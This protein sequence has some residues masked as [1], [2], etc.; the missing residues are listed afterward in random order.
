[1]SETA[2]GTSGRPG[3]PADGAHAA[4][5]ADAAHP[6]GVA[7]GGDVVNRDPDHGPN[8]DGPT[9]TAAGATAGTGTGTHPHEDHPHALHPHEESLADWEESVE[10][11]IEETV[12]D[13]RADVRKQPLAVWV[14]AAAAVFAF[15]GIGLVDPILP[16]IATNLDATSSQVS[17]LFTSY[18]LVTAVMMLVTGAISSRIGAKKTLLLGLAVIVIF[19]ALSGLSPSVSQLVGFR[20]GWGV[21]NSLFVATSLAVIVA[22]ASGGRAVAIIVYEAALG[23]GMAVGP[24]VG[25]LLG[26]IHWRAPFFGVGVLMFVAFVVLLVKLPT[27]PKPDKPTSV[28]DPLRALTHPGLFGVSLSALFYNF[29]FFTILAFT[30]FILGFGPYGIGAVFFGWGVALALFSVVVAPIIQN[31]LGTVNT[32][33]VTLV[34]LIVLLVLLAVFHDT[35]P[36]VIVLVVIS[37][38]LLGVNNTMYT[39]MAM[40]V[41]DAPQPVASAGYNFVRWLGGAIAPFV[42]TSLGEAAGPVLPYST[43]AVVVFIA[44]VVMV[45]ARNAVEVHEPDHV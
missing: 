45:G 27:I 2:G 24:L 31:R 43:A 1:M 9:G 38:A 20:A 39:E 18:F 30:P 44:G 37:G 40:S 34:G 4:H 21:G 16:A 13:E 23:L 14:T 8:G 41:S 22:V 29:G 12:V 15:M 32:T 35:R 33:L 42:A 26:G 36:V 6:G 11:T 3:T 10:A 17:L 5:R 19:A 25:A 28:I 7:G